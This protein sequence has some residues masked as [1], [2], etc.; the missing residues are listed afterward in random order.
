LYLGLVQLYVVGWGKYARFWKYI[1]PVFIGVLVVFGGLG[2]LTG[3]R[4]GL[5]W[6]WGGGGQVGRCACGFTLAFGRAEPTHPHEAAYG[7]GT[8]PEGSSTRLV[9][10]GLWPTLVWGGRWPLGWWR[11]W[12][13]RGVWGGWHSYP[14]HDDETIMNGPPGKRTYFKRSCSPT[15][16]Q[17]PSSFVSHSRECVSREM[18]AASLLL[19]STFFVSE[20]VSSEGEADSTVIS[21]TL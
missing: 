8:R 7:W 19:H 6:W 18:E 14:T 17:S 16:C 4:W 13:G 3:F 21:P 10:V 15:I 9:H 5:G 11:V 2:G 20:S 12:G 1:S